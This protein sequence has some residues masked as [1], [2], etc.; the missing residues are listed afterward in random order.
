MGDVVKQDV[1]K[2]EE[3]TSDGVSHAAAIKDAVGEWAAR[4]LV[5]SGMRIGAGTGSTAE[6]FIRALGRR[7]QAGAL[8]D[9]LAV[10]TGFQ[11]ADLCRACGVPVRAFEDPEIDGRLD[12][13]FDGADQIDPQ[14]RLTKGGGAAQTM[15]KV[16][17]TAA[18]RFVVMADSS[19]LTTALGRSFPIA[20]ELLAAA[21]LPVLR[22]VQALGGTASLR[23]A[24]RKMGPVISDNGNLLLDVVFDDPIDPAEMEATLETIP[25]VLGCGL[26]T[27]EG[28]EFVIGYATDDIR[29]TRD[30]P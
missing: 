8:Q 10:P 23:P 15:E 21:H 14:G 29:H 16:V 25:G 6:S 5:T 24:A 27:G 18:A 3:K 22:A 1:V 20:L 28:Y 11:S 13:A 26:F 17:A 2:Q 12:A 7:I 19:K 9:V 30:T 4:Q